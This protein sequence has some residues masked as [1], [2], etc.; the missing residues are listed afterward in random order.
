VTWEVP[1]DEGRQA[2]QH[3]L[4]AS[5]G[6]ADGVVYVT[7][8]GHGGRQLL[9]HWL[10]PTG[11]G[12]R[13]ELV[14]P[15]SQT[16]AADF[17]QLYNGTL[18]VVAAPDGV[19]HV[20]IKGKKRGEYPENA[21]MLYYSRVSGGATLANE[22][23]VT[24]GGQQVD[25]T[26]GQTG[27]TGPDWRQQ[28]GKPD[29][30]AVITMKAKPIMRNGQPVY[31]YGYHSR[32]VAFDAGIHNGG[33]QYF[34]DV[35]ADI[36]VDGAVVHYRKVDKTKHMRAMIERDATLV[37]RDLPR[38]KYELLSP[39]DG[40]QAPELSTADGRLPDIVRMR[41]GLGRK[42]ITVIVDPQNKIE[43]ENEDNNVVEMAFEMSDGRDDADVLRLT[44]DRGK[45]VRCG[46]NDLAILGTPKLH[47]NTKI[48]APGLMQ[49]PTTARMIVG[50]PRGANFFRNVEVMALLDGTEVWRHTIE[51]MD[52]TRHLY[53]RDTQWFGYTGPARR[54]GAEVMG[55]FLDVPVDLTNAAV[56]NHTL[57]LIVD[58]EDHFADLQ[59]DN[60][61]ASLQFRVREPGGTLRVS[62]RDRD[63]NTAIGRAHMDLP[64]LYFAITD[65]SGQ[66]SVADMPAGNYDARD[67]WA[68]RA[69]PDPRYGRQP[70]GAGFTVTKGQV[71]DVTVLLEAPVRVIVTV[72]DQQTGQPLPE[73]ADASLKYV[74]ES[75][76][77]G[78]GGGGY[79]TPYRQGNKVHFIDVPPGS[80]EITATGYAYQ[81]QT[82]TADVHRD[83]NG[84]CHVQ[85]SLPRMPRGQVTGRVVDADDKPVTDAGVWLN[86]APRW[87]ATDNAGN[88][89]LSE[90]EAGRNYQV[91]ARRKGY[92][93]DRVM[94][95]VVQAGGSRTVLLH[96]TKLTPRLS[97]KLKSLSVN[98]V[99]WAQIESWPGF[100][101]GPVGSDS[102]DVSAEHG[103]FTATMAMLYRQIQGEDNVMVDSIVL[104]TKGGPFWSENITYSYSL[105]SVLSTAIGEVAGKDIARLV[106]LVA[107][108]NDT[109]DFINGDTDPSQMQDGEV[110]GSFSSQ[111]GADYHS[112]AL[113]P[114]PS[115][116]F[117]PGM[118]GGQTVVRTD[119]LEVSDG[120]TTK[121]VRRQWYS[122]QTAVYNIGEKMALDQLEVRFYVAVLNDR[123]SPG[124]LYASSKNVLT[125]RPMEDDWL[126]FEPNNYDPIGAH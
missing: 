22:P 84:E 101:F 104:G 50:N 126:R 82:I 108:I 1:L 122:P 11:L 21:E 63:T 24:G 5:T 55:G 112:V 71:T 79:L 49:R 40:W 27:T 61:S 125:W 31:R 57:I 120:L 83:A 44:D 124:P 95:G 69:Y 103:K 81:A 13:L 64:G 91:V 96:I 10:P 36:L 80:C 90:V 48:A 12:E 6:G 35:E 59:P 116:E 102:Y 93:A 41:T 66:H 4:T 58:P 62:V 107:P 113:I 109:F 67:L 111:T 89:T 118:H 73:T 121:R 114:M 32:I 92:F 23:G 72:L 99:A 106:S 29:L 8:D 123:L 74:G 94:S 34:G 85:V 110:A 88:F 38:F 16:E 15:G 45:T 7:S 3:R 2:V 47:A 115:V 56:G 105:S 53:N 78:S 14:R 9:F 43:E 60:N 33:S 77:L 26:G 54:G 42:L 76:H 68:S 30:S 100:S 25:A 18:A 97:S 37:L 19:A 75:S 39:T 86:G 87:T 51:L 20:V 17:S 52:D 46:Y 28:G 117:S 98:C 65:A 119:I 70:A